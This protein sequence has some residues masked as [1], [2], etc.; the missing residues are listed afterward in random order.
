MTTSFTIEKAVQFHRRGHGQFFDRAQCVFANDQHAISSGGHQ[1]LGQHHQ[2]RGGRVQ[3]YAG[4]EPKSHQSENVGAQSRLLA[5]YVA[6]GV[7]DIPE[8]TG[9]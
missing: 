9:R 3:Q 7:Y 5:E 8:R 4:G 2:Q 6:G 1:R